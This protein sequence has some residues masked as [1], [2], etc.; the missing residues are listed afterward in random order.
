MIELFLLMME[1][2]KVRYFMSRCNENNIFR[3]IIMVIMI[4]A[5]TIMCGC[6]YSNK[7]NDDNIFSERPRLRIKILKDLQPCSDM[8]DLGT[9]HFNSVR[10]NL[11]SWF[12]F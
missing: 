10:L 8:S 4:I 9:C 2:Y 7:N 1:V 5:I 11:Y 6:N 12:F 3:K